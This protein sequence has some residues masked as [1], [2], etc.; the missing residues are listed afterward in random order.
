MHDWTITLEHRWSS[1]RPSSKVEAV[2]PHYRRGSVDNGDDCKIVNILLVLCR[3]YDAAEC[4][5]FITMPQVDEK[6][7]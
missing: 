1:D 2:I 3:L 6:G 5:S 7:H 4:Q